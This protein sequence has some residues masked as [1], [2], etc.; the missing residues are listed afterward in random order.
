M[1]SFVQGTRRDDNGNYVYGPVTVTPVVGSYLENFQDVTGIGYGQV[2]PVVHF[3]ITSALE[4]LRP[5]KQWWGSFFA[6]YDLGG[7][8]VPHFDDGVLYPLCPPLANSPR[9]TFGL[10]A[11]TSFTDQ[12]PTQVD[13]VNFGF[14][15]S[16]IRDLVPK[17]EKSF[18]KTAAG[19]YL[20]W[21]FGIKPMISDLRKLHEL[22]G[23]IARRLAW[24]R[25]TFGQRVRLGYS[26]EFSLSLSD[27][28][29]YADPND[30]AIFARLT[31]VA[32][33]NLFRAGGFLTHRLSG[34]DDVTAEAFALSAALGT[35]NPLAVLWEA[36]PFSF[37]VD[38]FAKV[39]KLVATLKIQPFHGEYHL[40]MVSHSIKSSVV[41]RL[42]QGQH[43]PSVV[44]DDLG[45]LLAERYERVPGLPV[46]STIFV[47]EG[48]TQ[49][50]QMLALALIRQRL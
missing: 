16:Q 9:E 31:P 4:P 11:Y 15:T 44:V 20:G 2:K 24:L 30:S 22:T 34:L 29:I 19:A 37:V 17:I 3:K 6:T 33:R 5:V 46:P 43:Y 39:Q 18:S 1:Q 26:T 8:R 13:I 50:Q 23:Y 27:Y 32:Q 48:L 38:W 35:Q 42:K 36:I 25:S 12:V 21:K 45:V 7:E 14:E 47:G 49:T 41:Y 40:E 28:V 10:E